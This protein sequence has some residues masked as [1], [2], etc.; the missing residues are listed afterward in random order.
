MWLAIEGLCFIHGCESVNSMKIT[1][2]LRS[3]NVCENVNIAFQCIKLEEK[4]MYKQMISQFM[5]NISRPT[6]AA[7]SSAVSV[8]HRPDR[9]S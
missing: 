1:A 6:T 7:L 3:Q 8:C 5:P 4:E 9:C 2:G